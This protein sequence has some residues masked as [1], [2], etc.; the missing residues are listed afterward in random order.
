[1]SNLIIFSS[2]YFFTSLIILFEIGKLKYKLSLYNL[3]IFLLLLFVQYLNTEIYLLNLDVMPSYTNL[4]I[5]ILSFIISLIYLIYHFI[6][7]NS[8]PG[9]ILAA[10]FIFFLTLIVLIFCIDFINIMPTYGFIIALIILFFH[11][12]ILMLALKIMTKDLIKFI[13]TC[14]LSLLGFYAVITLIISYQNP[15]DFTVSDILFALY[16]FLLVPENESNDLLSIILFFIKIAY[17]FI[18]FMPLLNKIPEYIKKFI[19]NEDS[20]A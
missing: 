9:I 1:M 10:L 11:M 18:F 8:V 19:F 14:F 5:L 6:S 17:T 15:T 13:Y 12:F 16:N 7:Y 3:Y 2:F 20:N 4:V